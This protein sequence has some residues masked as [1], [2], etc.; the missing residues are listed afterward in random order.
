MIFFFNTNYVF[1]LFVDWTLG[2]IVYETEVFETYC[3]TST[4]HITHPNIIIINILTL[5]VFIIYKLL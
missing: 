2:A 4:G 1:F 5:L 3:G